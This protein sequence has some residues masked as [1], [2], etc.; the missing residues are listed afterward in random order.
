MTFKTILSCGL[1]FLIEGC[2]TILTYSNVV[3]NIFKL[4]Q[5]KIKQQSILFFFFFYIRFDNTFLQIYVYFEQ[6][7]MN[8]EFYQEDTY[9]TIV[10]KKT[11]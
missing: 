2:E 3:V 10:R 11:L 5:V 1:L 6:C 9:V 7:N 4:K 8:I